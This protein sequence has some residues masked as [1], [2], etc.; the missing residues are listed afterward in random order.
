M[1]LDQ[2]IEYLQSKATTNLKLAPP[3]NRTSNLIL[4]ATNNIRDKQK[5]LVRDAEPHESQIYAINV[6]DAVPGR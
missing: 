3:S 6:D 2:A 4:D 5:K 1:S